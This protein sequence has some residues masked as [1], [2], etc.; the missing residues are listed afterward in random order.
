MKINLLLKSV[1]IGDLH[2]RFLEI[3]Q[4]QNNENKEGGR[5]QELHKQCCRT[6]LF[7]TDVRKPKK[8]RS[9]SASQVT[10]QGNMYFNKLLRRDVLRV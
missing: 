10:R 1:H 2:K 5:S 6:V 8:N 3:M 9:F 7:K 4:L